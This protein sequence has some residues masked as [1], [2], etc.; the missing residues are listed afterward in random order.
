MPPHNTDW[1]T[2]APLVPGQNW[3][4]LARLLPY[5]EQQ[6]AYNAINWTFGAR[7]SYNYAAGDSNPPDGAS[8][9]AYSIMQMT[10]LVM[11]IS[12]FLCPS[13]NAP[14]SSGTFLINGQSRL[15]GVP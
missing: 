11:Q 12:S 9:G 1:N 2:T 5:M 8:G 4:Q 3:S 6:T 14:G 10:V 7:W 15:V 13:D